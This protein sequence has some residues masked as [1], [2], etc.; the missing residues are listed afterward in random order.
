MTFSLIKRPFDSVF[1][2]DFF[3]LDSRLQPELTRK[4]PQ[5]I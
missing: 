5:P 4:A 3:N 2:D 1:F